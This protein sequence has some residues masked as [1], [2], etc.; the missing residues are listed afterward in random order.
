M[1][2]IIPLATLVPLSFEGLSS[3]VLSFGFISA[4][5]AQ[6][7]QGII[8]VLLENRDNPAEQVGPAKE[9]TVCGRSL[10]VGGV[11]VGRSSHIASFGVRQGF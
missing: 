11:E 8:C 4:V 7:L 10:Y 3:S 2:F 9:F 6:V 5:T 1:Y